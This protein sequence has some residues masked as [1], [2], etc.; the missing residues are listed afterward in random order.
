MRWSV[1]ICLAQGLIQRRRF[2]KASEDGNEDEDFDDEEDE[3][4][5]DDDEDY[6]E[7]SDEEDAE[8]EDEG[9]DEEKEEDNKGDENEEDDAEDEDKGGED[10]DDEDD[11]TCL[12]SNAGQGSVGSTFRTCFHTC[13]SR[14]PSHNL[15][16]SKVDLCEPGGSQTLGW[17]LWWAVH[18]AASPEAGRSLRAEVVPCSSLPSLGQSCPEAP[19]G[20]HSLESEARVTSSFTIHSTSRR[21]G[22]CVGAA[23]GHPLATPPLGKLQICPLVLWEEGV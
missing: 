3:D 12:W 19:S 4:E 13:F 18:G 11:D 9:E 16:A 22:H 21:K 7:D 15:E 20:S 8:D 17:T 23:G 10:K 2:A 6:N 14:L 5:E 1:T